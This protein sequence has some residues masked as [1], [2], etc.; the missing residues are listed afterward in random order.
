MVEG[1]AVMPLLSLLY[2]QAGQCMFKE[3]DWGLCLVLENQH[4]CHWPLLDLGA[5]HSAEAC[6]SLLPH[7]PSL[8]LHVPSLPNCWGKLAVGWGSA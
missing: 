8:L 5:G 3:E 7:V 6:S 2:L 1:V 4:C